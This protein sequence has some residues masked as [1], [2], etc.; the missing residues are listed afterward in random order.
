V[1]LGYPIA[2]QFARSGSRGRGI[3]ALFVLSPLL[4]NVVVRT[5]GW[6]AILGPNGL[7]ER[8]M[9]AI[10]VADPPQPFF[11]ETAVVIGLTHLLLAFMVLG[12]VSA[13]DNINPSLV[14]AARNLGSSSF[15][16]FWKVTLP[17][18]VP[19]LISG[20]F[21][22]FTHAC[23]SL[24]TPALLG[25]HSGVTLPTLIYQQELTLFNWPLGSAMSMILLVVIGA[26]LLLYRGLLRLIVAERK[27]TQP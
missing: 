5:Y 19:G 27:D 17:L 1:L 26:S 16:A 11:S 13:L 20:A 3:I 14:L 24:I 18:S 6:V 21:L 12:I 2:L 10:G 7:F 22:V 15:G 25:G 23:G 9:H 4:V 8:S